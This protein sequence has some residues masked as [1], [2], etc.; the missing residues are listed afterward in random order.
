[1]TDGS[2]GRREILFHAEGLLVED[3]EREDGTY[4]ELLFVSNIN[5]VQSEVRLLE[6]GSVDWTCL[7]FQCYRRMLAGLSKVP[8][9][10]FRESKVLV[11]GAGAGVL[12]NYILKTLPVSTVSAIEIDPNV[13]DVG[14]QFFQLQ[15]L[16]G[17]EVVVGDA[18]DFV[19]RA[20]PN[21]YS[22]VIV[23]I[24]VADPSTTSPPPQFYSVEFLGALQGLVLPRGVV[25]VNTAKAEVSMKSAFRTV[26][27]S[28]FASKCTEEVN[29]V[30]YLF[31]TPPTGSCSSLLPADVQVYAADIKPLKKKRKRRGKQPH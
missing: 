19:M 29:E 26:F 20:P 24:S 9:E 1:M 30:F 21:S 7:G 2:V 10:V 27:Q 12:A 16:Q 3:V 17:L 15:E 23:D 6:D 28:V 18:Y 4:R 25:A 31:T 13:I 8:L 22:L 14:R 11:L 5:E